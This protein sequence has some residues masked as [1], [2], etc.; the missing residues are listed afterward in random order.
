MAVPMR[1]G[2]WALAVIVF[3]GFASRRFAA[4]S[5]G[6]SLNHTFL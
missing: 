3:G 6:R 5:L 2:L 4:D 1:L